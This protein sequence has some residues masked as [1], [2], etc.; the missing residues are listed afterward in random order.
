MRD[1]YTLLQRH[2]DKSHHFWVHIDDTHWI[3]LWI[4]SKH[5]EVD[6]SRLNAWLDD[7]T[8][9]QSVSNNNVCKI[10]ATEDKHLKNMYKCHLLIYPYPHFL[11]HAD[12]NTWQGELQNPA[13]SQIHM[14]LLYCTNPAWTLKLFS[15]HDN[16][17]PIAHRVPK[18]IVPL[19]SAINRGN[20]LN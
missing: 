4:M 2:F 15:A 14:T 19:S 12:Q 16:F 10:D 9:C 8:C 3:L 13:L 17:D 11:W 1:F 5:R 20:F 6:S 7:N 18:L